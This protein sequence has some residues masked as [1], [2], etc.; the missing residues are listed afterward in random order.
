MGTKT[1]TTP[2]FAL[3]LLSSLIYLLGI[4]LCFFSGHELGAVCGII[5]ITLGAWYNGFLA[6][7]WEGEG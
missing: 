1:K 7:V 6:K 3:Q 2:I 4:F 5:T